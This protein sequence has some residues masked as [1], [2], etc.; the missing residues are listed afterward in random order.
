MGRLARIACTLGLALS[1]SAASALTVDLNDLTLADGVYITNGGPAGYGDDGPVDVN[2][3]DALADPQGALR[4]WNDTYSGSSAVWCGSSA[5]A[6]CTLDIGVDTGFAVTLD[7]LS[8]GAYPN[9]DRL[10]DWAI[11]DLATNAVVA[12]AT[13]ALVSG[14]AGLTELFTSLTST[15]GFSISFGPD[16]YNAGITGFTYSSAPVAAVPVPAGG[17]LLVGGLGLLALLRRRRPA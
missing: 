13:A 17:L 8:F 3:G 9:T 6:V 5:N 1:A 11:T 4:F 2:W 15:V 10:L 16:G 12:S 14:S 7:S